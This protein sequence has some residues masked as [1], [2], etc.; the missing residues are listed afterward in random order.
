MSAEAFLDTN[1][2]V[3]AVGSGSD[4]ELKRQMSEKLIENLDFGTSGQVLQEFY[5]TVTRKIEVPL[6]HDA[7]LG[8]LDDLAELPF[9]PVDQ[10]L[11]QSGAEIS[12]RFKT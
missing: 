1:V 3:Y 4:E 7:A 12:H 9:V 2:L 11:V 8:W 10:A 6:S 5:N